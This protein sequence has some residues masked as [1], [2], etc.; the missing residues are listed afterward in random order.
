MRFKFLSAVLAACVFAIPATGDDALFED[1]DLVVFLGGTLVERA[2]EFGYWEAALQLAHPDKTLHVRNFGWSGD[3]VWAESRGQF[4][5]ASKGYERMVEQVTAV[6]P[7]VIVFGYGNAEALARPT[8][9]E[10]FEKQYRKLIADLPDVRR[11]FVEPIPQRSPRGDGEEWIASVDEAAKVVGRLATEFGGSV[12]TFSDALKSEA[13]KQPFDR[14]GIHLNGDGY[15][16]TGAHLAKQ[17]GGDAGGDFRPSENLLDAIVAKNRLVFYR[18]RPQNITY[19]ALFR[20][21]EQGN[22]YAEI[23]QF[24]PLIEKADAEIDRIKRTMTMRK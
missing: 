20:K 4:D 18:W 15:H 12:W 14:N 8:S 10:A 3:T 23:P 22:N 11:V 19:L 9:F 2:Q 24:D 6:K 17:T 5:P 1:G 7:D 13:S 16:L 21:H